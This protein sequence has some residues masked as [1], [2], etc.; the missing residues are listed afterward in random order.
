MYNLQILTSVFSN[1]NK[2]LFSALDSVQ[3]LL[4]LPVLFYTVYYK[5]KE[6]ELYNDGM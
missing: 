3:N 2:S 6:I 4:F 5:A 1:K